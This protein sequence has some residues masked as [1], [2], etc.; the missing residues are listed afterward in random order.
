MNVFSLGSGLENINKIHEVELCISQSDDDSS[1]SELG[2]ECK[3][4]DEDQNIP[5]LEPE[6]TSD[7]SS[8]VKLSTISLC[9]KSSLIS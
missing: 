6:H 4:K 1:D 5:I 3:F 2:E 8:D 9:A 7:K